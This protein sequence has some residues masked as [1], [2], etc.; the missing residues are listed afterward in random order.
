MVE[1][2]YEEEGI[3]YNVFC[4]EDGSIISWEMAD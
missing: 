2:S 4:N 3:K 1:V